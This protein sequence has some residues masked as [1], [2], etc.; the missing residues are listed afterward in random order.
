MEYFINGPIV[1]APALLLLYPAWPPQ[2][3]NPN[4]GVPPFDC[5]YH[6]SRRQPWDCGRVAG[7]RFPGLPCIFFAGLNRNL[8]KVLPCIISDR[9]EG[10]GFCTNAIGICVWPKKHTVD[11]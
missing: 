8:E 9:P 1:L 3:H 11:F 10:D 4:G 6:K 2:Y 5:P 7:Q